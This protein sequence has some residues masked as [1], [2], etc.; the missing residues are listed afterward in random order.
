[1]GGGW[2]IAEGLGLG[3][4]AG[5][6]EGLATG[7]LIAQGG[8][9]TL[10]DRIVRITT[11]V[12]QKDPAGRISQPNPPQTLQAAGQHALPAGRPRPLTQPGSGTGSNGIIWAVMR[13]ITSIRT[14]RNVVA[15]MEWVRFRENGSA[16]NKEDRERRLLVE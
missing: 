3:L 14:K 11:P 16:S 15:I 7:G 8:P 13:G 9:T 1:M 12:Q 6:V 10:Q 5:D 2:G 4:N